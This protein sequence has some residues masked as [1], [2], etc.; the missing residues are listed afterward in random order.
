MKT[1][2][3]VCLEISDKSEIH[4]NLTECLDNSSQSTCIEDDNTLQMKAF[5]KSDKFLYLALPNNFSLAKTSIQDW[6]PPYFPILSHNWQ[7]N[8]SH[9]LSTISTGSGH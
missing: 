9:N 5:N 3:C 2:R 6:C 8:F 7:V 4:L 1:N